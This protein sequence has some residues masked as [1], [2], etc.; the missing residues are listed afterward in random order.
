MKRLII[1]PIVVAAVAGCASRS[2]E[3]TDAAGHPFKLRS[4]TVLVW[5]Q[6]QRL[7]VNERGL[8]I[9]HATSQTE[10]E[11][12]EPLIGAVAAGVAKGLKP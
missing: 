8:K 1:L 10:V 3:G 7:E 5:G 4:N 2:Y 6:L 11:K 12:L 9:G